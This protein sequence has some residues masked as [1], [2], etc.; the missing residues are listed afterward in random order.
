[1]WFLLLVVLSMVVP[2]AGSNIE[3]VTAQEGNQWNY[4]ASSATECALVGQAGGG[5]SYALN[6]DFLYDYEKP[7]HNGII[8][9]KTYRDLE[10][11]IGKQHRIFPALGGKF[12]EQKHVWIFPKGSHLWM[13]YLDQEKDVFHYLGW[14]FSWIGWDELPQFSRMPY[15]FMMSRLRCIDSTIQKR[16][17]STGNADGPGVGWVWD[18]FVK[19]L[20]EGA[21]DFFTTRNGKDVRVSPDLG[22]SRQWFFSD[23]AQNRKLAEADPDYEKNLDL[24][25]NE[26]L[27]QAYKFGIL[28]I[29]DQPDQLIKTEWWDAAV[30]GKNAF[31]DGPKAFGMDYAELGH[32]K[33]ICYVGQ[34]NQPFQ[35]REWDY[36]AH[37]AM[38][39][40][41]RNIF[42]D[43]GKF[44]VKG[45]L[46]T[47]GTGAGVYTSLQS[48]GDV[49]ADRTNPIRYKDSEFDKKYEHSVIKLHF[50][51]IQ[52]QVL[53]KLRE[54][55]EKGNIDLSLFTSP[56]T[57][58]ENLELLK[59]EVLA[60][61]Y[62]TVG[63][64]VVIAS[65]NDLRKPQRPDGR[66]S[67]GR[68]PDRLKALAIWNWSR[69][70]TPRPT[71]QFNRNADDFGFGELKKK[72]RPSRGGGFV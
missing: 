54:D 34:G 65:S 25:P 21:I 23:R 33:S 57:Y 47:V 60:V 62:K 9:R 53:W 52:D 14:E 67:L 10:D 38:A 17:R 70:W 48:L 29:Q 68:S 35:A 44:Q 37:P 31:V 32:D 27:R 28:T 39:E 61:W 22:V 36:V 41:L 42:T 26:K 1:M 55:F 16:V 30:N 59:E 15:L 45:G 58:Y 11:L 13:S 2:S 69:D 4:V 6:L 18:R 64:E 40:I 3:I 66:P 24:L 43:H 19:A 56:D 49:F 20:P 8:F 50:K 72:K 71:E 7:A 51:N 5:K 63:P 46:D 12:L